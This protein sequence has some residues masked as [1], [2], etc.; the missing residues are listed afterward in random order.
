MTPKEAA[1]MIIEACDTW[2]YGIDD[3]DHDDMDEARNMAVEALMV[4]EDI[5]K[6]IEYFRKQT[7]Q[8]EWRY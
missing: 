2:E 7:R 3:K 4:T 8:I 6:T 1:E 5:C